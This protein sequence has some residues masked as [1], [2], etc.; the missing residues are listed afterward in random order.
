MSELGVEYG[1]KY[2]LV[3]PDGTRVVFNDDTDE[4]FVGILSPDTSGLDASDV[5]EDAT[6]ATEED[7]GHHGDFYEGRRPVVLVGTIISTGPE[8]RNAKAAKLKRASRAL[9]EDAT[10][11]WQPEGGP[12]VELKLRRQQ[13]IRIT[14]G[15]VKDFSLPMVAADIFPKGTTTHTETIIFD[16]AYYDPTFN[17]DRIAVNATHVYYS[18]TVANDVGRVTVEGKEGDDEFIE[19]TFAGRGLAIDGTYVY[20]GGSDKVGR[21][22]LNGSSVENEWFNPTLPPN[23]IAVDATHIYYSHELSEFI[24]RATIAGAEP[25]EEWVEV[26]FG[27]G[28]SPRKLVVDE[29]H[30]YWATNGNNVARCT[31]AGTELEGEFIEVEGLC[32]MVAID[33]TY[34]YWGAHSG[35]KTIGRA[36]LDGSS[37]E[38][39]WLNLGEA[40]E[41][42]WV[43][44]KYLYYASEEG[45]RLGKVSLALAN[46]EIVLENAGDEGANPIIKL[47][48][49]GEN[50]KLENVTTGEY[51]EL[52]GVE[53][54]DGSYFE[55]DFKAHTIKKN[56]TEYAYNAFQFATSN[57]WKL[58]PGENT[59]AITGGTAEVE[60]QD[61][62][63]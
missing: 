63:V 26:S 40:P 46:Q 3:G 30:L 43:D 33:D 62:Y 38:E 52:D 39:E 18:N 17:I 48:G 29:T 5:R 57:W 12:E 21:A 27:G 20:W 6:D 37:V 7:G 59:I 60:W 50:F 32:T 19:T 23:T 36:K 42:I 35:R 61:T 16:T 47:Y 13:P 28:T 53:L 51:I 15:Y 56:G 45:G 55:I 25:N 1:C 2:V 31:V 54:P 49:P 10:L 41:D 4:D 9:R 44:E 58:E 22:K 11:T 34:I 8:D 24:G 14:K